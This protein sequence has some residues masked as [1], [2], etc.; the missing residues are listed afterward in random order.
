[1]IT[2]PTK[3]SAAVPNNG[4]CTPPEY[5]LTT[6]TPFVLFEPIGAPKS[7]QPQNIQDANTKIC[8]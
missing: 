8:T 4:K 3:L 7:A 1:M 2:Q 6:G 5:L